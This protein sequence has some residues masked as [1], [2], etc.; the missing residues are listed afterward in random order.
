VSVDLAIRLL[1]RHSDRVIVAVILDP[2]RGPTCVDGVGVE[3]F[4]RA[5]DS[6]SHRVL[7][8]ISGTLT[9][10][11]SVQVELRA[12]GALPVGAY[13]QGQC[14]Q[15]CEAVCAVC[16]ADPSTEL[17]AHVRGRHP[18]AC[19]RRAPESA[20]DADLEGLSR[21]ERRTLVAAFPWLEAPQTVDDGCVPCLDAIDDFAELSEELGLDEAEAAMLREILEA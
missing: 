18:V 1:E 2:C 15:G 4:S 8:P 14:W 10:P 21:D 17:E 7:L 6:L 19:A 3:L 5:R 11:M 20:F 12:H 16:P 9:Q 13:V